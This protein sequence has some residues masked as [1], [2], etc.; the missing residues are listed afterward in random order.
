MKGLPPARTNPAP[1]G[2]SGV[3]SMVGGRSVMGTLLNHFLS[4]A[5]GSCGY[6]RPTAWLAID[7]M[8]PVRKAPWATRSPEEEPWP[9]ISRSSSTSPTTLTQ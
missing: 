2:S 9:N 1:I 5:H 6:R 4:M 8:G 7:L 3:S